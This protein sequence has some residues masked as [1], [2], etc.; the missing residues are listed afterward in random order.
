MPNR[1]EADAQLRAAIAA[2]AEAHGFVEPGDLLSDYAVVAAWQP[3]DP[4]SNTRY[5]VAYHSDR[6]PTHV[7]RGLFDVGLD[8]ANDDADD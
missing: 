7:A 6:V 3:D 8:M 2:H 5:T 4:E 1:D